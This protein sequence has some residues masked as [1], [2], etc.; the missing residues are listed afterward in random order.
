[1]INCNLCV[2]VCTGKVTALYVTRVVGVDDE[3]DELGAELQ[4]GGRS[5]QGAEASL[6]R[7]GRYT[8]LSRSRASK[9]LI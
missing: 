8:G 5:L 4:A 7:D 6:D 3:E 9:Q 2:V 1:M